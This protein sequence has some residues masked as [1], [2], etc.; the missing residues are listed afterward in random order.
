MGNLVIKHQHEGPI[1]TIES[2]NCWKDM[3]DGFTPEEF[4]LLVKHKDGTQSLYDLKTV[5]SDGWFLCMYRS[6]QDAT[7][8]EVYEENIATKDIEIASKY[9]N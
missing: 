5:F 4:P 8:E 7:G 9:E 6:C 3:C 1:P 2:G